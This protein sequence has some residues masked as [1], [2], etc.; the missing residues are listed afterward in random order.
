MH[1]YDF[2]LVVFA[3]AFECD[4]EIFGLGVRAGIY[5]GSAGFSAHLGLSKPIKFFS[6]LEVRIVVSKILHP[7]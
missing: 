2:C 3:V 4:L 6:A 5:I 7:P 1:V